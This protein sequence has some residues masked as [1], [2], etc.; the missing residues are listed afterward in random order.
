MKI[1]LR[2][3]KGL[4]LKPLALGYGSCGCC[5][6]PWKFTKRHTTD[7]SSISGCFPLCEKCW[8]ELS[9]DDRVIYYY[10]LVCQVWNRPEVWE[11]VYKAVKEGK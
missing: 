8:S 4:L 6:V 5:G 7:Y 10:R 9:I 2:K 3:I 11:T 1:M